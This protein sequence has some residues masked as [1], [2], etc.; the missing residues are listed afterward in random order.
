[1]SIDIRLLTSVYIGEADFA[2][3]EEFAEA[4]D[5]IREHPPLDLQLLILLHDGLLETGDVAGH[6]LRDP[7]RAVLP[8]ELA[9]EHYI[10]MIL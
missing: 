9:L 6:F 5:D 7:V 1:M 3:V 2:L 8:L 10:L 4:L